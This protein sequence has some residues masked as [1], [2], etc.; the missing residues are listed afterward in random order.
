MNEN[1][2]LI[3][4]A[5]PAQP[6]PEEEIRRDMMAQFKLGLISSVI[7][8]THDMRSDR[9]ELLRISGKLHTFPDGSRKKVSYQTLLRWVRNYI[10]WGIQ[11]LWETKRSDRG[12]SRVLSAVV[13]NRMV[14]ILQIVP[15]I[16]G[17]KMGR[18]LVKEGLLKEGE[19][20]DDTIRRFINNHGLRNPSVTDVRIRRSFIAKEVGFLWESDSLYFI[21]LQ[22]NRHLHWVF[23]QAIIDD[24]SRL[25]VSAKCYWHDNAMNFQDTFRYGIS[26][27]HIPIKLFVDNG[28]PFI[29]HQLI[30]ICNRL[31]VTLIHTRANDGA[32]KGVIERAWLSMLLDTIPDIIL[33]KVETIEGLQKVVDEYVL[34]YNTKVNT[35]VGGIPIDRYRES[36]KR[37]ALRKIESSAELSRMFMNEANHRVYNDNVI[38]KWSK[39]WELPDEL[40]I[41]LHRDRVK[42]V[43]VYFDPHDGPNTLYICYRQ[44]DYPLTLH[45]PEANDGKKRNTGGRKTELAERAQ[46]ANERKMSTAE[47]R[48][49]ER[50]AVRMAGVDPKYL[51]DEEDLPFPEVPEDETDSSDLTLDYTREG[52]VNE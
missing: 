44:K 24:H 50:Y 17:A 31:G 51:K 26:R 32:A 10:K 25:I 22:K 43:N 4:D 37:I 36:E 41:L 18:R 3:P 46:K 19:V 40:V 47:R 13:I 5:L 52:G 35:G 12:K 6:S 14:E 7:F 33:D 30:T 23:V 29:D 38:R 20:S 28:S 34:K 16:T 2:S 15:S 39:K 48:A 21:K 49:E 1:E 42:H 9:Q 45:D 27:Y 8:H 11:G